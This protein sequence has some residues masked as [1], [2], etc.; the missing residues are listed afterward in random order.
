MGFWFGNAT[1]PTFPK[2]VPGVY[3]VS[4]AK[5]PQSPAFAEDEDVQT[6]L[7]ALAEYGNYPDPPAFPHCQWSWMIGATLEQVDAADHYCDGADVTIAFLPFFHIYGIT[8]IALLGQACHVESP[9][10]R[11]ARDRSWGL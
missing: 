11:R 6:Y 10:H 7:S 8:A 1:W 5:A 9:L 2:L 4:F 3:S